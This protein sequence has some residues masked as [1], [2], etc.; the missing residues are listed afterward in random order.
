MTETTGRKA[1]M[2]IDQLL[3]DR[4][5][6]VGHDFSEATRN[7]VAWRDALAQ[8]WR[9]SAAEEDRR[10]LER[11]NAGLSVILGGQFPVGQVPW[12]EI[13]RTR[14]DLGELAGEGADQPAA[15]A[16]SSS[17]TTRS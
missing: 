14:Q 10:A 4:P 9:R 12:P 17:H 2:A 8:R 5:D 7:L 15:P 13:Q 11:L 6:K 16:G 1:L 3:A